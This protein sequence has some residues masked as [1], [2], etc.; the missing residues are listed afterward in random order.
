MSRLGTFV[1]SIWLGFGN[2]AMAFGACFGAVGEPLSGE[3]L[4]EA[5]KAER[6]SRREPLGEPTFRVAA[7]PAGRDVSK[8]RTSRIE[9]QGGGAPRKENQSTISQVE[10]PDRHSSQAKNAPGNASQSYSPPPQSYD[11]RSKY[12][13]D[14]DPEDD[15]DCIFGR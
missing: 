1:L 2:S 13:P 10:S 8:Q 15:S 9:P 6:A 11:N 7:N 12:F 4:S 5:R 3:E 14:F